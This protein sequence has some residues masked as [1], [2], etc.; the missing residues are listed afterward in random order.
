[1]ISE[2]VIN[3]ASDISIKP[4]RG[5]GGLSVETHK[6]AKVTVDSGCLRIDGPHTIFGD[7][8]SISMYV[9]PSNWSKYRFLAYSTTI[10]ASL[11]FSP[12]VLILVPIAL[13]DMTHSSDNSQ[14]VRISGANGSMIEITDGSLSNGLV[15][16][17]GFYTKRAEERKVHLIP[18]RY[19]AIKSVYLRGSSTTTVSLPLDTDRCE[20]ELVGSGILQVCEARQ[21]LSTVTVN[22]KGSGDIKLGGALIKNATVQV[23][24]S[25]DVSSF[26]VREEGYLSV[27]GS[28]D[29]A[30]SASPTAHIQ[31]HKVG[32]G[33]IRIK[34]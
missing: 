29:I 28:G 16:H 13:Y 8:S 21:S 17:G 19:T 34:R 12:F 7:N 3:S 22:L 14:V 33:E 26:F 15:T 27:V 5:G 18:C 2:I 30:C 9:G 11:V 1:M 25:G 23:K 6:E 24:G 10:I 20:L 31:P 4:T 32:S